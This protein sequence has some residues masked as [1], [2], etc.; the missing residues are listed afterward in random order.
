MA[1]WLRGRR[2]APM[3]MRVERVE[4]SDCV[5]AVHRHAPARSVSAWWGTDVCI[6]GA[7]PPTNCVVVCVPCGALCHGAARVDE[8]DRSRWSASR[9]QV[10]NDS[11]PLRSDD[12]R[13][14]CDGPRTHCGT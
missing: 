13:G 7:R 2:V 4:W 11:R 6:H 1:P 12:V 3:W 5:P 8:W 14:S 9:D 10:I